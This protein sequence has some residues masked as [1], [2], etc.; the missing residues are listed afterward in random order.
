MLFV[1]ADLSVPK[2]LS[3]FKLFLCFGVKVFFVFLWHQ[4]CSFMKNADHVTHPHLISPQHDSLHF[5]V[6]SDF[7][8]EI[9][10]IWPNLEPSV[11]AGDW[12][13]PCVTT[14][15][16]WV[17]HVAN[18]FPSRRWF[19]MIGHRESSRSKAVPQP[20]GAVRASPPADWQGTLD[21]IRVV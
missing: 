20:H 21:W 5:N 2:C 8:W 19:P 15:G 14:V 9:D 11:F 4:P 1:C 3:L 10:I 6:D 16:N 13:E 18:P 12:M 17:R 7:Q